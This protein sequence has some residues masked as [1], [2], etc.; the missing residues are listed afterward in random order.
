VPP[1]AR[2]TGIGGL[3]VRAADPEALNRWYGEHFGIVPVGWEPWRQE[4]GETV[5]S[6]YAAGA[7]D[8]GDGPWKLNLRV[9]DLDAAVAALRA[10][11]VAVTPH[12]EDYEYGR[13]AELAD[14]EGNPIQ[15][16]EPAG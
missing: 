12:A 13:F 5:V 15:L 8:Y 4:A 10:A 3:F 9:E 1:T 2:V 7:A 14:P 6:A 11:G 16:W